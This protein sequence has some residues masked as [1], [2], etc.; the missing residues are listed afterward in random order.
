MQSPSFSQITANAITSDLL[1]RRTEEVKLPDIPQIK[2]H[3]LP[4]N[5][6]ATTFRR[7]SISQTI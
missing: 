1:Q 6:T 3:K 2:T 4:G 5:D 7:F